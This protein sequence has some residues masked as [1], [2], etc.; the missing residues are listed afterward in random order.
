MASYTP[1]I[2][3][4]Q[5]TRNSL[6]A[7]RGGRSP[8]LQAQ[9]QGEA[10]RLRGQQG[11]RDLAG[12]IATGCLSSDCGFQYFS[13]ILVLYLCKL[14]STSLCILVGWD[15]LSYLWFLCF[16]GPHCFRAWNFDILQ[17]LSGI[18]HCERLHSESQ[19]STTFE[20]LQSGSVWGCHLNISRGTI[21]MNPGMLLSQRDVDPQHWSS[22]W[23][24]QI[25]TRSYYRTPLGIIWNDAPRNGW[26]SS[27][28]VTSREA[29]QLTSLFDCAAWQ[30][31][32]SCC[33]WQSLINPHGQYTRQWQFTFCSSS[34]SLT[35]FC[36]T[37]SNCWLEPSW[38]CHSATLRFM[39]SMFSICSAIDPCSSQPRFHR[40]WTRVG[41]PKLILS[42]TATCTRS[43]K[44]YKG[45][46]RSNK[47]YRE[48][49]KVGRSISISKTTSETGESRNL[50]RD[51]R[52]DAQPAVQNSCSGC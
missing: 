20:W 13:S 32:G 44:S 3:T 7:P 27:F 50:G 15:C 29:D 43:N 14:N 12:L 37:L 21:F 18:Y 23:D 25:Y 9:C 28:L 24:L 1:P 40:K 48:H 42:A 45:C 33:D 6:L 47:L 36:L 11:S 46:T 8:E 52:K 38:T 26:G 35:W 39:T 16:V 5:K 41:L 34:K 17:S 10:Y 22:R 4:N 31:C 2:S 30:R 19:L 51:V 49:E